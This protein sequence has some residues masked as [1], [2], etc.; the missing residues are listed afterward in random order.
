MAVRCRLYPGAAEAGCV[1]TAR[2]PGSC[3]TLPW[4]SSRGGGPVAARLPGRRR[5][6]ASSP[7][8]GRLSRSW[9]PVPRRCS[10]RPCGDCD[11][12]VAEFPGPAKPAGRPAFRSAKRGTQGSVIRDPKAR[13]LNRRR[14]LTA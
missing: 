13:R 12:A 14:V 10:S 11:R 2:M 3:G 9:R 8:R 1:S 4:S 6:S 5:G 7:G